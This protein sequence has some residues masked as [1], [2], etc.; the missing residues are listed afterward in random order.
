MLIPPVP[1]QVHAE[2]RRDPR[3]KFVDV[4]AVEVQIFGESRCVI[5]PRSW[6][7]GLLGN[8]PDYEVVQVER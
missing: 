2:R 7:T 8:N 4:I 3:D 1:G 5:N 6:H